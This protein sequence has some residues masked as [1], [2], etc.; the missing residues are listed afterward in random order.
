MA[1]SI[2]QRIGVRP[3]LSRAT[4]AS[5]LNPSVF[6]TKAQHNLRITFSPRAMRGPVSS[7]AARLRQPIAAVTRVLQ[8]TL[9]TVPAALRVEVK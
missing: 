6:N 5:Q 4:A 9:A 2:G 3:L 7:T 1:S 8:Q